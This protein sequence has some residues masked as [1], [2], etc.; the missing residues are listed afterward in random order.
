MSRFKG[1]V[2]PLLLVAALAF[3]VIGTV[4][5]SVNREPDVYTSRAVL[6]L[7]PRDVNRV[8]ADSLQLATS[9]YVA[10]LSAPSTLRQVAIGL[11]EPPSAVGSA[12]EVVVQPNTV[13]LQVSVT[14]ED[15][16]KAA[17]VANGIAAAGLRLAGTDGLVSMELVVPGVVPTVPSGPKRRL[18]MIGG[19]GAALALAVLAVA[20]LGYFR[21]APTIR[22]VADPVRLLARRS[23]TP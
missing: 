16:A 7:S 6:S 1:P 19:V 17:A 18:I 2:A 10:F 23:R 14:M 22:G 9:R 3:T 21:N 12:S 11:G 13:N 15:P 8:G 4:F 5:L 20:V